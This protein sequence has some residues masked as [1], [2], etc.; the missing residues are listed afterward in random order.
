MAESG[1]LR[2]TTVSRFLDYLGLGCILTAVD[3]LVRNAAYTSACILFVLGAFLLFLGLRWE[4]LKPNLS[5]PLYGTLHRVANDARWWLGVLLGFIV[6]IAGPNTFKEFR[7]AWN[8]PVSPSTA[9]FS[10]PWFW[11]AVLLFALLLVGAGRLVVWKRTGHPMKARAVPEAPENVS[12]HAA[13]AVVLSR[14]AG[15]RLSEQTMDVGPAIPLTPK[16]VPKTESPPKDISKRPLDPELASRAFNRFNPPRPMVDLSDAEWVALGTLYSTSVQ[17][18]TTGGKEWENR[19]LILCFEI[20]YRPVPPYSLL[21]LLFGYQKIYGYLGVSAHYLEEGLFRSGLREPRGPLEFL[22][23]FASMF[24]ER[25]LNVD[26][27]AKAREIDGLIS[28]KTGL[29]KGGYYNLTEKGL[30]KA[31]EMFADLVRRA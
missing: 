20:D 31:E 18:G 29:A 12:V 11:T 26:D 10:N 28:E 23:T 22:N 14:P 7:A 8:A 21:M 30:K 2:D 16:T 6:I 13:A 25:R 3:I 5:Q 15:E 9:G 17:R 1:P 27:V 24:D 19:Y 4:T